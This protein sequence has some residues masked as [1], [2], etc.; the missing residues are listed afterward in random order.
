[1]H[2]IGSY[3]ANLSQCT[4]HIMPNRTESSTNPIMET[5]RFI[6][7]TESSTNP[8]MK[9]SRFISHKDVEVRTQ[10]PAQLTSISQSRRIALMRGWRP[11]CLE[12]RF[13]SR[14]CEDISSLW[15]MSSQTSCAL[16][17]FSIGSGDKRSEKGVR[18][19]VASRNLK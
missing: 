16:A 15:H 12:N 14:S 2:L 7:N 6:S 3:C 11:G 5:S 9:T 13:S 10:S 8:I 19:H 18:R 17:H 1:M 4:V